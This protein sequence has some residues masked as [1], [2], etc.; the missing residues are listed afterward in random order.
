MI[1]V[2]RDIRE[3]WSAVLEYLRLPPEN[4]MAARPA[5]LNQR[6][7]IGMTKII[8]YLGVAV[9]FAGAFALA[10]NE[11]FAQVR[12]SYRGVAYS[13]TIQRLKPKAAPDEVER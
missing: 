10:V 8:K 9:E 12:P 6:G 4:E 2:L 5:D 11:G 1:K 3:V 13:I 7:K